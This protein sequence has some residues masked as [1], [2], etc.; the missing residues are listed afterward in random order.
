MLK[1]S[2][3]AINLDCCVYNASGP[4]SG[5]I[6][7]LSK[8]GSSRSGAILSKSCT[9]VKQDGNELPRAMSGIDLG[10]GVGEGSFNS[11]G[12]PNAGIDYYISSENRKVF[13]EFKKPY[14]LSLSGKS[15]VDNC[16]MLERA[17]K[18]G[19]DA[20]ELNLAC[21]NVPGKPIIAY[22]FES[23]RET[24]KRTTDII[25]KHSGN[26][27]T[28][29]PVTF[30]VKLAPY[31]D[32]P[33]FQEAVNTVISYPIH[34]ITTCNSIG[35][36]LFVDANAECASIAGNG[37]Y[38]GLA[39]GYIKPTALANIRILS[40]LLG[41][42]GRD[43]VKIVGVGGITSGEDAFEAILCGASAVQIGSCHWTEGAKCFD[44]IA[45]ELEALMRS[46]GYSSIEDFR[47]KLKPY[48]PHKA[49]TALTKK[50][51]ATTSSGSDG[52]GEQDALILGIATKET[53]VLVFSLLIGYFLADYL[54][55]LPIF[56]PPPTYSTSR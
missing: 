4:R 26:G 18:A 16:E 32:R 36:A 54:G 23:M 29:R 28:G 2:V 30:G 21:P 41:E 33:H 10:S 11:E 52:G 12:L 8:V 1:S 37:G 48:R 31:F 51:S 49:K 42:A 27:S 14:I 56:V 3:G 38:G 46:K 5:T 39:G 47:G 22:D 35:N 6:E 24:C 55:F 40:E 13:A 34:F 43:D 9:L 45:G 17:L 25:A 20:V 15:L 7:A 44:R 53:L 19:I 50:K